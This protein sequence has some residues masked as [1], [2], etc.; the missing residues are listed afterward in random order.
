MQGNTKSFLDRGWAYPVSVNKATGR[1]KLSEYEQD[2]AEAIRIILTTRRGERIMRPEFGSRLHEYIFEVD[3][4]GVR[5]RIEHEAEEAL[6]L[7]EPRI[8]GIKTKAEFSEGRNSGFALH[9]SYV[10]RNTNGTFNAVYPFFIA[11]GGS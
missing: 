1:V 7:W 11:E 10:V 5:S 6:R 4:L 8:T 9:I 3:S 2:I